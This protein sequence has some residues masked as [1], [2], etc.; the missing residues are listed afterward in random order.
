[1][2]KQLAGAEAPRAAARKGGQ[3]HPDADRVGGHQQSEQREADISHSPWAQLGPR[4]GK[5]HHA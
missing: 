2:R 3:E 4:H 1:M 5:Q